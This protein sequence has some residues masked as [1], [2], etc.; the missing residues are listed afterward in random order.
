MDVLLIR[1]TTVGVFFK[2][3]WLLKKVQVMSR[4]ES[5]YRCYLKNVWDGIE[6][7]EDFINVVKSIMFKCLLAS[8]IGCLD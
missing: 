2:E 1:K 7:L 3:V 5:R 8:N 4:S 6:I